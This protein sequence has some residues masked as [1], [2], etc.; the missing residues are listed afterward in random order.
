MMQA[1]F[2]AKAWYQKV[3]E[4]RPTKF[5]LKSSQGRTDKEKFLT[6]HIYLIGNKNIISWQILKK[7][8]TND[9]NKGHPA[10]Q[11]YMIMFAFETDRKLKAK[12]G[13]KLYVITTILV[14]CFLYSS[15]PTHQIF[16]Q[17]DSGIWQPPQLY[18]KVTTF[19]KL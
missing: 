6:N 1:R 17:A 14:H 5:N 13:A 12:N 9:C 7:N 2:H 16:T 3:L 19:I 11:I 18:L 4:T 10:V 15:I 8:D